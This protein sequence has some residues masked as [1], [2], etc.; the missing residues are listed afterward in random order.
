M[1]WRLQLSQWFGADAY[2]ALPEGKD[3][4][5]TENEDPCPEDLLGWR[6]AQTIAGV[7]VRRSPNCVADNPNAVA[8]FVRGTNNV[9]DAVLL[10]SG[11]TPDAVEKGR[12]L[13]G[14]GDPDE[15]HIR[16]EV[17]E[18]NG[19]SPESLVPSAQYA[20]APGI[21]P[22][23]WVFAPK[24]FGMAT[25]NFESVEARSMLRLPSPAIR[26]EQGDHV[27]ITLE[28]SHYMP[29]TIHFHGVDHPYVDSEGEGND[30]V[31]ITSE[32]PVMPGHARTYN[33]QPRQTGTM[34]YHCHVQTHVHIMMGLQGLFVIEENRPNNW[35]QTLNVGAGLVRAPS[36]AVS[37][38]FD[39]EY[40]LQ[41]LDIDIDLNNRIQAHNDPRLITRDMHR[42]YDITDAKSDYFTLNGKSFPYTFRESLIVA[43]PDERIKLRVVNGGSTGVALHTHGHKVTATHYDGVN[44][45]PAAQIIRDVVWI[46]SAQRVDLELQTTNDGLHSYGQGIWLFHDHQG[47][48]VTNDGLG[49]GGN[50]SAIVYEDYLQENGWP[51]T[52]GMDLKQ[53]FTEAYY[54]KETPVWGS[55]SEGTFSDAKSDPMMLMR[56]LGLGLS[57]GVLV[58]MAINAI[59]SSRR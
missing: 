34:F 11:L 42:R 24:M 38:T 14:D 51:R 48:G 6:E 39:R 27:K 20:I 15:I 44:V 9:S 52:Q 57:L 37:E 59:F 26:V 46:A 43:K 56:L 22:G 45:K 55:L 29:H 31:P 3:S 58:A 4:R 41:Y 18:L 10:A 25:K 13:D 21:K 36:V 40:D 35:V 5:I 53:F 23:F 30:G 16:L 12:D 54:R 7:N 8:A 32:K 28:N 1:A 33:M 50:V 19:A 2:R 47:K 49:P 17:A